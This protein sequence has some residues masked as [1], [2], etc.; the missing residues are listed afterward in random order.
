[1]GD[2]IRPYKL[3]GSPVQS[4]DSCFKAKSEKSN[5]EPKSETLNAYAIRPS[6]MLIIR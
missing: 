3:L 6:T 4:S 2:S 1:M 5:S